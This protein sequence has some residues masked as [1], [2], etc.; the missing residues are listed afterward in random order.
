MYDL[1]RDWMQIKVQ[2]WNL[3]NAHKWSHLIHK[4][5]IFLLH[6]LRNATWITFYLNSNS[7]YHMIEILSKTRELL[8]FTL[9]LNLIKITKIFVTQEWNEHNVME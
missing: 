4:V 7:L 5:L 6:A 2:A 1:Y 3:H 8:H 9:P